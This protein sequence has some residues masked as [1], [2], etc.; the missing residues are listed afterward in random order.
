MKT[1][2]VWLGKYDS[3]T[4]YMTRSFRNGLDMNVSRGV[5]RT[6]YISPRG[7]FR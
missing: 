4:Y 6:R 5:R 7:V 1:R 2:M 3:R